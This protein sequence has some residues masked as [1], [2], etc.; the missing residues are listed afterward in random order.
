MVRGFVAGCWATLALLAVSLAGAPPAAA[1]EEHCPGLQGGSAAVDWGMNASEQIGAGFSSNNENAPQ[2]VLGLTG[3][4]QIEAGFKF[5]LALLGNCTV[6]SWGTGNKG[7]LGNGAQPS[8]VGHPVTVQGLTEVKEIAAANAHALA[9]RYDGTV[10]TWGAS[11]FGER[12]NKEKGFE[13]IA[14]QTEPWFV[15]RDKPTQVPGLTG[16]KQI[17]AGGRR[18]Y[19]LLSDGQVMAWG[20]DRAGL[21]GVEES[22]AEE[23]MCLGEAHAI[24]PVQCSTVPRPVKISGLGKLTG[25]ERIDAGEETA[26]AIAGNGKKVLAWGANGKG[27][28]GDGTTEDSPSPVHTQ[29]S[30]SSPVVE[31]QGGALHTLARLAD[32][33]LYAWGADG[34]GQLGFETGNEP[35][36]TCGHDACS[37]MPE[38]VTALT[39]VVALGAG[40]GVSLAVE[41]EENASKVIYAFGGQGG[42]ELLGLGNVEFTSTAT[43]T[44]IQGLASVQ[45]ISVSTTTAVATLESGPGHAPLL[46]LTPGEE[47]LTTEWSVPAEPYKLRDRPVGTREFSKLLE[48]SCKAPCSVPLTGLKPQPYEVT[49]KS[50]EGKEGK[51]KDR[52]IIGTPR[53]P[54]NWPANLSPPTISGSPATETGKLRMGQTL[55]AATGTWSGSPTQFAYQ[56]LRCE[57][58]AEAG[59]AE[60]L[61][62]ECEPITV[63][64]E[65]KPATGET[66]V[67]QSQDVTETVIVTVEAKNASGASTAV[68]AAE[69][70]LAAE[71]ESEP[72]YPTATARPTITGGAVEGFT[73]TAH[74]G[75]WESSPTEFEDKWFRCKGVSEEGTGATCGPITVNKEPVIGEHYVPTAEDVGSWIEVQER[76]TNAGGWEQEASLAV[77]VATPAPPANTAVPTITGNV[78]QGQTLTEQEGSWSNAP[79]KPEWQWYR[80]S[81][82]GTECSPIS[83]GTKQTHPVSPKDV[84]HT[85]LVTETVENGFA[86]SAAASSVH[87]TVVPVPPKSPP[88][89]S[90]APTITGTVQQGHTITGH[91]ATW[92]NEPRSFDYQWKRCETGGL[93]CHPINEADTLKYTL[94]G[95][96]VGKVLELRE[97]ATNA[98]GSG[99]ATSNPTVTVTGAV[100]VSSEPPTIGGVAEVGRGL[101]DFHGDWS[102]EPTG[103]SYQW[104]KCDGGGNNCETIAGANGKGYTPKLADIGATLRVQETASNATGAGAAATSAAT[105]KVVQSPP[106]VI[107]PPTVTGKGEQGQ[108]LSSHPGEWKGGPTNHTYQWLR[109]EPGECHTIE[110]ATKPTYVVKV[111]DVGFS[112]EVR[113]AVSN[114]SGWA[115]ADSEGIPVGGTPVPFIT[116]VEPNAGPTEGG[117]AVTITG[118]NF[119]EASSVKFGSTSASF[120]VASS[121]KIKATAP[122]GA[123]GTVTITVTTPNGTSKVD[124]ASHFSYGTPPTLTQVEPKEGPEAG[125][126]AVTIAGAH[127]EEATAVKFGGAD[128]E[129]FGAKSSGEIIAITPPG[130]GTVA[131]TVKTPYGSTSAAQ[132]T[133]VHTGVP[134]VIKKMSLKKGP[135]AGGTSIVI[136]GENFT[137]AT[138]VAFGQIPAASFKVISQSEITAESPADTSG[139]VD[140]IITSPYGTNTPSGKDHFRFENPIITSVTPESG[141]IAGG[142]IVR[143]TG[144]GFA[145]GEGTTTFKFKKEPAT[146]VECPSTSECTM[147]A[148]ADS[149]AET[150]KLKAT[151]N[152]K[153]SKAS[154][155][156]DEYSYE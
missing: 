127:L 125:G 87:T 106:I 142:T 49:L 92:S 8:A 126:T 104:E 82:S 24:T 11:E 47:S 109:C 123:G 51:E 3:V 108:T 114:S 119:G 107:A 62:T 135:A 129:S 53:P 36:E 15:P 20:E 148:P 84:G 2:P 90:G 16:V 22:G 63:G 55:K 58:Y 67:I 27:E 105:E 73:L 71:E 85:L 101:R 65:K 46:A 28:L 118:G 30:P 103:Y 64:A 83:K 111:A 61:G 43:P 100:P 133:Y 13:R 136:T 138:A 80:C 23:E 59:N 134:P 54:K 56:W 31:I 41:E 68:S 110:G 112:V 12:G 89:T 152:G 99:I 69:V 45:D 9:L 154:D 96:D 6:R 97:T 5:G 91:S 143:V 37:P 42:F 75:T 17:A 95:A 149:K 40:E 94:V 10:W 79:T 81:S 141:P 115:A 38:P 50:P 70:I 32:G 25:V 98:A 128:A 113:E 78:E 147:I 121:S 29:L 131:V 144:S 34:L 57:G 102:N 145:L 116:A 7:Q 48:G 130:T 74:H 60:E 35:D 77:Q 33:E 14:R 93:N 26:Y 132:F 1:A 4:T 120:E 140:V 122:P 52:K 88:Q 137:Y 124:T 19:A 156:G 21:L 76:A 39:H 86:R 117:T 150:V 44:A 139:I 155:P 72:P 151:A 66:Y 146:F 153:S 18:D